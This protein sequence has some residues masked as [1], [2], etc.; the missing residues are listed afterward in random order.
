MYFNEVNLLT[1]NWR[2]HMKVSFFFI[3]ITI[4]GFA[5]ECFG[6]AAPV[7][8]AMPAS[9]YTPVYTQPQQTSS[10]TPTYSSD[11]NFVGPYPQAAAPAVTA[12]P[13]G[14]TAI[15]PVYTYPASSVETGSVYHAAI[16][17]GQR[18][19]PVN[20][21]AAANGSAPFAGIYPENVKA[22]ISTLP[23]NRYVDEKDQ[24]NLK[25]YY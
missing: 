25:W 1:P 12:M 17:A 2:D 7:Y 22:P 15:A 18:N 21:P 19:N 6:Q 14:A 8:Y 16:P 3:P 20:Y 9:F 11:P 5:V 4:I 10:T 24:D 13:A 23:N